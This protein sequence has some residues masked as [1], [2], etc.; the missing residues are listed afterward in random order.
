MFGHRLG[1]RGAGGLQV[2]KPANRVGGDRVADAALDIDRYAEVPAPLHHPRQQS[3]NN[4]TGMPIA[5][6][7]IINRQ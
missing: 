5:T 4:R 6:Q 1:D 7:D 3:S 2:I